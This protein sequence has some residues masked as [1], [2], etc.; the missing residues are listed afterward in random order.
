MKKI[1]GL[2]TGLMMAAFTFGQSTVAFTDASDSYNKVT[3]TSFN[4]MF[5]PTHTAED[6]SSNAAYYESYFTVAVTAAGAAGNTVKITLVE[7]NEMARRV[8]MRLLVNLE[9]DSINVNGT[10]V[11]RNAFMT[12]YIMV[13]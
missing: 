4:F 7:D 13:D 6:I 10:E 9:V 1:L 12:K 3:A 8:I 2:V 5:S 11:E